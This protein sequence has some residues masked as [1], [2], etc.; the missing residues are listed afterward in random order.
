M[1]NIF[2]IAALIFIG[3]ISCDKNNES[4]QEED[5]KTL[6]I[7]REKISTLASSTTCDN[8]IDWSFTAIGNKACGG[9]KEYIAYSKHID[10]TNFLEMVAA[11]TEAEK[12]YNQKWN[13]FSDCSTPQQPTAVICTNGT[14]TFEY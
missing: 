7:L 11:Y 9:P 8:S 13:V 2:C 12:N 14:P 6:N 10:V 5:L 1:K 3:L 4:T